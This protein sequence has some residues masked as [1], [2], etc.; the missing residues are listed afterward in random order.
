MKRVKKVIALV[1][2]KKEVLRRKRCQ[3]DEAGR[4][5]LVGSSSLEPFGL[6][7]SEFGRHVA[8]K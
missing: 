7:D 6:R 5:T 2:L 4:M 1:A 8:I 3:K